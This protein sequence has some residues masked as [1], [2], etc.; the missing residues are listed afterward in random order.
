MSDSQRMAQMEA[1][2]AELLERLAALE[3]LAS[4][5]FQQVQVLLIT[6]ENNTHNDAGKGKM[7][8]KVWACQN[9]G[10]MLGIYDEGSGEMRISYKDFVVYVTDGKIRVPCRRCKLEN[11]L[12]PE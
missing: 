8:D 3:E 1:R 7:R 4:A 12:A 5:T 11:A 10:A 9:C 6:R 2:Q